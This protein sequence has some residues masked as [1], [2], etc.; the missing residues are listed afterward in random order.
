MQELGLPFVA[1]AKDAPQCHQAT[2]GA[3]LI[4]GL[5]QGAGTCDVGLFAAG[6]D[7]LEIST[8]SGQAA[9]GAEVPGPIVKTGESSAMYGDGGHGQVLSR[10]IGKGWESD[11]DQLA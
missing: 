8:R 3:E 1:L 10:L 7:Q 11:F 2:Y 5:H 9:V 6:S 4:V